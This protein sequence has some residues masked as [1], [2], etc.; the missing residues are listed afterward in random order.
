[1]VYVGFPAVMLLS[2]STTAIVCAQKKKQPLFDI[3]RLAA[4][5]DR[6]NGAPPGAQF[7]SLV[8]STSSFF[9]EMRLSS[10]LG[11]RLSWVLVFADGIVVI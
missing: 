4:E 11:P 1:M 8:F 6:S 5:T 9:S 10:L 3:E 2:F 7:S